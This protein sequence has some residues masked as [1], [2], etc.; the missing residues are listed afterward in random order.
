[1]PAGRMKQYKPKRRRR[2]R[3]VKVANKSSEDKEIIRTGRPNNRPL[4]YRG[5]GIPP[6]FMTKLKYN[7]TVPV[8]SAFGE[9]LF[10]GNSIYDPNRTSTGHQ[11]MY[12]DEFAA[13]YRKYAV[14]ASK[15]QVSFVNRKAAGEIGITPFGTVGVYPHTSSTTSVDLTD[16]TERDNCT[17]ASIGPNTGDQGIINM[18]QYSKTRQVVG[19]GIDDD[20]LIGNT[21]NSGNNP[22]LPWNW[23]LFY[24][25]LDAT[26]NLEL[27]I[28]VTI[29]YYIKFFDR[30]KVGG[31]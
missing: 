12:Q 15:I 11:P 13:L 4:I 22:A 28:T 9:Y 1:M 21:G 5:I 17:Y 2:R 7:E 6:I 16:A 18:T 29:T 25:S 24:G 23:H 20:D 19:K 31:S 3:V 14:S 30:I 27:Y 8:S 10:N 26:D